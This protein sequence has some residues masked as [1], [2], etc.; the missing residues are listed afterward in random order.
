[1]MRKVLMCCTVLVLLL[2]LSGLAHATVDLYV[3]SAPNVFGSPNWAP[4]WSQTKSDIVGGS[5]TNLRTAT[6]PGTNIVDPYDFIVYSTGDLGKRLHFAYW[7]P[8]ESISNL[9]TGLF[10]VKW[11][12]DWDGETCTTDAGGNWIPDASNSG[13]VQPTRWEAY[14]DGTNAGVIGS[15][16]F[17]YWASDNDALPN[18]TDGNPY[19]ETNQADIDALRSATLASQTFIKGEVRYRTATTEEWQNTSLQVNVVPEPVSS[20]LFLV[21]AATLGFRRFR[22]NIKG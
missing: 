16:G 5:M 12:V 4:W 7:L 10:E 11:S 2:T 6:Y 15:M 14:D 22:K 18:G 20:A 21:G 9:S 8:G 3:D 1:M 13:W 19:N 17:A